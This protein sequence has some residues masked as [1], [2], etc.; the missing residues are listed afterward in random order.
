M[1]YRIF[2]EVG[3]INKTNLSKTG[4]AM[5]IH[6]ILENQKDSLKFLGK[7]KENIDVILRMITELKKHN[8]A[9]DEIKKQIE[10]TKGTYLKLKLDEV[11]N[12]Y[13]EYEQRISNNFIDEDDVLTILSKKIVDSKMFENSYVFIDEFSGF[14]EQE[15]IIINEILNQAKQVNI[16]I[17]SDGLEKSANPDTDIFYT[18]KNV[19]QKLINN[20]RNKNIEIENPIELKTNHRFNNNE[21]KFLEQNIYN[22]PYKIYQEQIKN[23]NLK[24]CKNQYTEI[25]NTAKTI[26]ELVRD[27]EIRFRDIA[28]VTK[29]V[30][31]YSSIAKAIFSKYNIP[32]FIDQ[33]NDLSK[34]ILAKYILAIL[35]IYAKNWSSESVWGYIKTGFLDIEKDKLYRLE[36]YCNKWGIKGNKWFKAD[37]EYNMNNQDLEELNL[38]RRKI[39]EPLV[40]LKQN[41]DNEKTVEGITKEIYEFLL[42]QNIKDK[43]N[44]KIEKMQEINEEELANQYISSWNLLINILDEIVVIFKE[45]KTTFEKYRSILK[46]GLDFSTLGEIPQG[47][48]QVIIG[49]IE[50]S[51]NNKIKVIFILGLNDGNFPSINKDEG[52]LNDND[53][54][55]LKSE[56]MEIAKGT[57][58]NLYE[59]QFNIYKAFSTAEDKIYL[60]YVSSDKEGASKRPSILIPKIK[61]MFTNLKE[62][63]DIIKEDFK[64]TTDEATF[65][66]LLLNIRNFKNGQKIDLLWEDVHKWY[67]QNEKWKE[68]L[69]KAIKGF[70][71]KNEAEQINSKNIK[72]LY[73]DKLKTSISRLEQYRNCPF[74]F[75]LKYGLKLKEKEDYNITS[76]DTGSFMHEVV[77]EF[78]ERVEDIKGVNE[79]EIKKT[80]NDII[81]EKL[82]LSKN[83]I[84]SNN[85][86][87]IALT[88]RLKKVIIQSIQYI[89][90][91]MQNS[92]FNIEGNEVE[93]SANIEDVEI[94]G[95]IDRIDSVK[96]KQGKFIRI[97]DYKSSDHKIDLNKLLAG[98]QIQLIT[99]IDSISKQMDAIPSGMLYFKLIDPIIKR[100][101]F[102][103]DEEIKQL[104]KK[105]FKMDGIILAD[106]NVIRL[107]DTKLEKGYSD[108]IPVYINTQGNI[109]KGNSN[110]ITK[111]EFTD[112]QKTARK[113]I[114]QISTDILS[115]NIEIKPI[116][117]KKIGPCKYCEYKSICAFDPKINKYS[118]VGK[119]SKENILEMIKEEK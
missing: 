4:R 45:Q 94:K 84:F 61:K 8:I 25:E 115:G 102:I 48:D 73:G 106:V 86:K 66:N 93:F 96:T 33:R 59:D 2:A 23:I 26:I 75:H 63:S 60:S 67:L 113:I 50:R 103:S 116:Y 118:Y 49:D 112:L 58:E 83:N 43:L 82:N 40:K 110:V 88:N 9:I 78:F 44:K 79:E 52:F 91:Q 55:I 68:K 57:I 47:L 36:N 42:E 19:I 1:A 30:D 74:S 18:N 87:F 53:R 92:D 17:C 28:I 72:K 13:K 31:E 100:E 38:L 90:E 65:G 14:T 109:S 15:Y 81:D 104:I 11:C 119:L 22:V 51:R 62:E 41:I 21:L 97:I 20:A 54:E 35:D 77:A 89:V 32:I 16:A 7:S 27:D 24:I 34:N 70:E 114:K 117:D 95:K 12:I 99:Y 105:K 71:Y 5:I 111:E 101:K 3:G 69:L 56:G 98:I 76:I 37:W 6:T 80:V 107:M 85:F 64:I 10:K 108:T 39:V 46:V 29:N